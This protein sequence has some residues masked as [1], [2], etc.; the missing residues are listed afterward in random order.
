MTRN[1]R[2]WIGRTA[3]LIFGAQSQP[4]HALLSQPPP[5]P[6]TAQP[7]HELAGV[8]TSVIGCGRMGCAI[9][10]ELARR[11]CVVTLFDATEYTRQRAIQTLRAFLLDHVRC[12]LLLHEDVQEI[13]SRCRLVHTIEEAVC[14][15]VRPAPFSCSAHLGKRPL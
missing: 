2:A 11:G 13:I 7:L 15:D 6:A 5:R 14:S 9:A 8:S 10:G 1:E 3:E 4:D 12:D